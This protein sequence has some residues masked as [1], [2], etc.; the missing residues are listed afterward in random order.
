VAYAY[1]ST[2][3]AATE[4]NTP[5]GPAGPFHLFASCIQL[6]PK[7]VAVLLS[8]SNPLDVL[9]DESFAD[10]ENGAPPTSVFARSTQ[11]ASVTPRGLFGIASTNAGTQESYAQSTLT[12]TSPVHGQLSLFEYVSEGNNTCHLSLVWIPAA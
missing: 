11:T 10:E 6:G 7:L 5:L 4:Q 8:A 3:P 1:D 9:Y 12:L 2:A